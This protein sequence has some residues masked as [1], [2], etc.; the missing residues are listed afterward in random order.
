M[1]RDKFS[2]FTKVHFLQMID[3]NAPHLLLHKKLNTSFHKSLEFDLS[4]SVTKKGKVT[5]L[6]FLLYKLGFSDH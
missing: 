5:S 1:N 2:F 4:E 6:L 3:L